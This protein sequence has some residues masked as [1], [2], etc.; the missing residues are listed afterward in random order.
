M[1]GFI[2]SYSAKQPEGCFAFLGNE[3]LKKGNAAKPPGYGYKL[4]VHSCPE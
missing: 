1:A 3:L 4:A 2:Q